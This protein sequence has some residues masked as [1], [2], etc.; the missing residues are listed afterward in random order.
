M[1][2]IA[3]VAA[4]GA[5]LSA[6]M[7]VT[8]AAAQVVVNGRVL[9]PGEIAWLAQLSCGPVYPGSYWFDTST[10]YWGYAGSMQ[11]QGHIRDRCAQRRPS[12]SERRLLYRPGEILSGN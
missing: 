6:A 3:L 7:L 1:R 5:G 10:G 11:T 9:S 2:R 4:L 8:P 12:L